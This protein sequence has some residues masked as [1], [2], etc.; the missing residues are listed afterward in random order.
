MG[1]ALA[2]E[3]F[4]A[5]GE[6]LLKEAVNWGRIGQIGSFVASKLRPPT[7]LG[8]DAALKVGR[9]T[10]GVLKETGEAGERFFNPFAGLKKGWMLSSPAESAAHHAGT[11]GF[12]SAA[13]GVQTL[14]KQKGTIQ[15]MME[16]AKTQ[17]NKA[18]LGSLKK[19]LGEVEKSLGKL[20]PGGQHI[21][22]PGMSLAEAAKT[23]GLINKSRAIAEELSRRGWTGAGG[24]GVMSL[25]GA[26]KYLPVG[27]KGMTVGFGAMGIPHVLE[28]QKA[29]PTGEGAGLERGLGLLG[30]T[31]GM[32]LGGGL[33]FLPAMG[34][35]Y[36][37]EKGG[38]RLG[39]VLDRIRAGADVPTAVSAPSPEEAAS[40]MAAIQKNYG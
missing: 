8:L 38:S 13:E 39:R 37:A 3:M 32:V 28:A 25:G 9:G 35:W 19:Q 26:T 5:F 23:P 18:Q 31:G 2:P 14:T 33:G 12:A 1:D 17:G 36:A 34:L 22:Q 40:Q 16:A 27:Q 15:K 7:R 10:T 24:S 20:N 4:D 11:M 21:L 30:S 6:E 29:T